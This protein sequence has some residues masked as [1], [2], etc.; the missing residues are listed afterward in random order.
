M[1]RVSFQGKTLSAA[2]RRQL[3]LQAR[4]RAISTAPFHREVQEALTILDQRKEQGI[5]PDKQHF[6]V[7]SERGTISVAEWMGF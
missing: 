2:Q 6:L 5:K 1:K 7:S 4:M 3:E